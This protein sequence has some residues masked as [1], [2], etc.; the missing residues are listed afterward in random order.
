[1]AVSFFISG[2]GGLTVGIFILESKSIF[3]NLWKR[4]L[5]KEVVSFIYKA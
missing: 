5:K 4:S 3:E 1:M 2:N